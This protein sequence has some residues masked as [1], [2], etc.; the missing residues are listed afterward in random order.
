[1]TTQQQAS[2]LRLDDPWLAEPAKRSRLRLVLVVLLAAALVFYAGVEVQ[3]R[4]GTAAAANATAGPA[5]EGFTPPDSASFPGGGQ[6]PGGGAP[7]ESTDTGNQGSA[8]LDTST[9]IGTVIGTVVA[10]KGKKLVVEDFGGTKHTITLGAD[11]RV[12]LETAGNSDD[13]KRGS[14]V[15]VNGQA[16]DQGQVTAT[17]ITTR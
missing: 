9:V 4:Y 6:L 11:V 17:T 1:M 3:R 5:A 14:T 12:V 16:D 13:L 10:L 2:T 8:G 15:Q 7:S